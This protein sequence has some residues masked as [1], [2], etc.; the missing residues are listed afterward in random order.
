MDSL[1]DLVGGGAI[2][3]LTPKVGRPNAV[4]AGR[5]RRGGADRRPL[6]DHD[7]S[8]QQGLVGHP[9]GRPQDRPL[10]QPTGDPLEHGH[11]VLQ[12]ILRPAPRPAG[13]GLKVL[14]RVGGSSAPTRR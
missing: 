2:W 10:T 6:A 11:A 3:L 5:H 4:D 1:T 12:T 14:G 9:A 8:G 7:R 13:T